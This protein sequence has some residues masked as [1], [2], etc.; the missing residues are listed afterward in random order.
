MKYVSKCDTYLRVKAD[1][2]R[3]AENLQPLSIIEWKW[4][5]IYMNFIVSLSA[6]HVN[7]TRYESLWTV[8]LSQLPL[9]LYLTHTGSESIPNSTYP[10]L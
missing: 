8:L 10:T 1:H 4:K 9:Y 6:P 5:N 3:Q 7:I 2:L